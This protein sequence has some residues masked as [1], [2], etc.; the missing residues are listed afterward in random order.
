M[1][2]KRQTVK[3][4]N[5]YFGTITDMWLVY[6]QLVEAFLKHGEGKESFPDY[7]CK[8]GLKFNSNNGISLLVG[9]QSCDYSINPQIFCLE[10]L[11]AAKYFFETYNLVTG[12]SVYNDIIMDRIN[13]LLYT[14]EEIIPSIRSAFRKKTR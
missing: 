10:V 4:D 3:I 2:R 8:L 12:D 14:L 9:N 11:K 6:F 13:P 5:Q 1:F 7:D